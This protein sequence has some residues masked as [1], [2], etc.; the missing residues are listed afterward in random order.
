MKKILF[1]L[2]VAGVIAKWDSVSTL[3]NIGESRGEYA[4]GHYQSERWFYGH[5][6]YQEARRLSQE[7]K[8]PMFIY[9]YADWCKYCKQFD[10]SLLK[11]PAVQKHLSQFVK[12]R[13]NPEYNDENNAIGKRLRVNGYPSIFA[14]FG[15]HEPEDLKGPFT[16]KS[17]QWAMMDPDTFIDLL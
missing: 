7:Q 11:D 17:G 1:L 6:G 2:I 13:I 14:D 3:L 15:N 12:V 16:K 8:V 10:A 9:I 5:Q 4:L